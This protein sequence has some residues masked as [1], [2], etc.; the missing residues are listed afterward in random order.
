MDGLTLIYNDLDQF[1]KCYRIQVYLDNEIRLFYFKLPDGIDDINYFSITQISYKID[2]YDIYAAVEINQCFIETN[3]NLLRL[4]LSANQASNYIFNI[5][6]IKR[7]NT[8][9][10]QV[11]V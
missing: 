5:F 1:N 2:D 10:E 6:F 11:Q 4:S 8:Y 7:I 3:R 9:L